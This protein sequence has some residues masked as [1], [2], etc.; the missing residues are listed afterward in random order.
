MTQPEAANAA[1]GGR[2]LPPGV[3]VP[4]RVIE[5]LGL[6]PGRLVVCALLALLLHVPL[7]PF[8]RLFTLGL[9]D[10]LDDE[11]EED[12]EAVVPIEIEVEGTLEEAPPTT[13][14]DPVEPPGPSDPEG[15]AVADAGVDASKGAD[16]GG[17]DGGEPKAAD[18]APPDAGPD[19]P[20]PPPKEPK[21]PIADNKA[22]KDLSKNPNNVQIILVGSRLR[23][24]PVG[25]KLG[26]LLPT[27]K[28]WEPFFKGS[29]INPIDD[30]DAMVITGPQVRISGEVIAIMK[31]N[32]DMARVEE[33]IQKL[34]EGSEGLKLEDTPV[35]AWKATADKGA[36][37]FAV[38]PQKGLLYVLPWPKKGK[39][40]K[41]L[42]DDEWKKEERRRVDQQLARVKVAKFPDYTKE[43]YAID[44]YMVEPYKL[45]SKTGEVKLGPFEIQLIPRSLLSLRIHVTPNGG[46]ADVRLTFQAKTADDAA[47]AMED[48]RTAWPLLQVGAKSEVG[49]ELPDL[50]WEQDGA[51]IEAEATLPQASLEKVYELGRKHSEDVKRKKD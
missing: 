48:L 17:V 40:D 23:E 24:H 19:A 2:W 32:I 41:G 29:G 39:K 13:K 11:T 38:V 26:A 34:A 35:P 30:M 25:A 18:A 43:P 9:F 36:R 28:Q 16:D 33:T 7:L 21:E 8:A 46:D 3:P 15:Y 50:T 49:M 10:F 31:F 14:Q 1:R 12:G 42:S 37:L 5:R 27:L 6:S 47:S 20:P 22:I 44:A 45:V 4:I 51:T